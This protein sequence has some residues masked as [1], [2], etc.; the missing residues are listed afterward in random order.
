[1]VY[2]PLQSPR[3]TGCLSQPDKNRQ[4]KKKKNWF[5]ESGPNF[6]LFFL[7]VAFL[8]VPSSLF[9]ILM[10]FL[11]PLHAPRCLC[12]VSKTLVRLIKSHRYSSRPS[13]IYTNLHVTRHIP[14]KLSFLFSSIKEAPFSDFMFPLHEI[15]FVSILLAYLFSTESTQVATLHPAPCPCFWKPCFPSF[16]SLFQSA[17]KTSW[18]FTL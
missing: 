18:F 6:L 2:S 7:I 16:W 17:C 11:S 13:T 3:Q 1:V 8:V 5:E 9:M 15:Y 14:C 4:Q 12:Y 10:Y